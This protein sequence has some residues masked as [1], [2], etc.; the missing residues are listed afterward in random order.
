MPSPMRREIVYALTNP[1]S[2][3]LPWIKIGM[4]T[5][6]IGVR[7]RELSGTSVPFPY[8]LQFAFE[9]PNAVEAEDRL[10]RQ[11]AGFR[12]REER[13]FFHAD[14]QK[15]KTAM[16]GLPGARDITLQVFSEPSLLPDEIDTSEPKL[17]APENDGSAQI[18]RWAMFLKMG[19]L[20]GDV[21]TRRHNG[22]TATI[23]DDRRVEFE[24]LPISLYDL[25]FILFNH[26]QIDYYR[27]WFYGDRSLDQLWNE[28]KA[29]GFTSNVRD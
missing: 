8:D 25:E 10:H 29:S 24:K 12:A 21:I 27:Q 22:A 11:F 26:R 7:I 15:V 23:Y 13:E 18:Y 2:F 19:L 4:T 5:R 9:V 16:R 6:Q 3:R 28:W 17:P 20:K 14:M 1:L